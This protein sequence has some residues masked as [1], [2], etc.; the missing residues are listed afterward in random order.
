MSDDA[1]DD[2]ALDHQFLPKPKTKFSTLEIVVRCDDQGQ[3][4][5]DED[6]P[7]EPNL[8]PDQQP[9]ILNQDP[10]PSTQVPKGPITLESL[11]SYSET[12]NNTGLFYISRVPP[13][14]TPEKLRSLLSA[15][16]KL[17][18]KKVARRVAGFLNL[19]PMGTRKRDSFFDDLWNIRY[20]PRFKCNHL[21][22]QISY[23]R[24]VR[25]R[26]LK[27]EMEQVK[28]E[29]KAYMQNVERGKMIEAIE[30]KK[31]RKTEEAGLDSE[32]AAIAAAPAQSSSGQNQAAV[33][34]GRKFKQREVKQNDTV[35]S[36][37]AKTSTKAKVLSKIF[38]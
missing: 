33:A 14:M 6:L 5:D 16:G 2:I 29:T 37:I 8:P 30:T 34:A 11:K 38:G 36:H 24:A 31:K 18:H 19:R 21:T 4:D 12:V 1:D 7:E 13:F 26:K 25:D 9:D 10:T 15:H 17:G 20:L 23:E 32:P 22:D 28:R 3:D 27:A 35:K